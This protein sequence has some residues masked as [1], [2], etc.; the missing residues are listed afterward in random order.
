MKRLFFGALMAL[1]VLVS[2]GGGGN[3]AKQKKSV[4]PYPENSPVAKYGRLQVKDLQL[5]DKD[6][7]PVQLAGM[8]TMGWQWC[9][10][11]ILHPNRQVIGIQ[12]EVVLVVPKRGID[13]AMFQHQFEN[14]HKGL[15]L[16]LT[17]MRVFYKQVIHLIHTKRK[18][19]ELQRGHLGHLE[20]LTGLFS[21]LAVNPDHLTSEI[22]ERPI[23][24]LQ[25]A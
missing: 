9:G 11:H 4:S 5:C 17:V 24:K 20:C 13:Y 2:C 19:A 7:N 15:F 10:D 18:P 14:T 6:G 3:N 8:S 25:L 22:V 12:C 23:V 1:V 21:T 16:H